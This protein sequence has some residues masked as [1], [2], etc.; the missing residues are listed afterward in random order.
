M[1]RPTYSLKSQQRL[2][3]NPVK[4]S[5]YGFQTAPFWGKS[6]LEYFG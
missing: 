1:A 4:M 6:N 2:K 3:V 5:V